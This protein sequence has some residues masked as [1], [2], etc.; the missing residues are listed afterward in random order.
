[1]IGFMDRWFQQVDLQLHD[2]CYSRPQQI[3]TRWTL[4]WVAPAPWKPAMSIPGRSELEINDEGKI[5][6]HI[7]YWGLFSAFGAGAGVW[8]ELREF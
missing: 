5:V 6:S 1:M 7:D 4:S 2:I 8:S 3:D